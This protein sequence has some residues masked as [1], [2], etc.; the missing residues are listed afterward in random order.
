MDIDLERDGYT[1]QQNLNENK[2]VSSF[3]SRYPEKVKYWA[4]EKNGISSP[5]N[6]L[7]GSLS[8][9]WWKCPICDHSWKQTV[10]GFVSTKIC[11]NCSSKF[12]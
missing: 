7:P 12:D 6:V 11:K 10:K 8:D 9:V 2:I 3:K 5:E 4:Y 1:I